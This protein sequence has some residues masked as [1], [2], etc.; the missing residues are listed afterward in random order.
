MRIR[1]FWTTL[2][3]TVMAASVVM[4]GPVAS[5]S[6]LT[7]TPT[8]SITT[9]AAPQVQ[10]RDM[11]APAAFRPFTEKNFRHNLIQRTRYNPGSRCQAH[12]TMPKTFNYYFGP[13]NIKIHEPQYG[14]WWVSTPG[15][16]NNHSAMAAQYN[17]DWKT[18]IDANPNAKKE[19]VLKFNT[20]M[21]AKY[22][23]YYRC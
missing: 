15:V 2:A 20:S 3:A 8:I 11:V 1:K 22:Q 14:L 21:V 5:A 16:A 19:T 7:S 18:W 10:N 23:K 17:R 13:K 4:S 6:S 9:V 12:H